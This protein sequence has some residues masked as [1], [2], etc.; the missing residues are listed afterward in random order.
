MVVHFPDRRHTYDMR[1]GRYLGIVD[2]VPLPIRAFDAALVARC[3]KQVKGIAVEASDDE[4]SGKVQVGVSIHF[5]PQ[6]KRNNR[7]RRRVVGLEI[8]DPKG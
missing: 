8:I 3:D 6:G 5:T 4:R 2:V 1:W 7:D